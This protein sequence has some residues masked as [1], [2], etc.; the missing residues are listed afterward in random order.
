MLSSFQGGFKMVRKSDDGGFVWLKN[1]KNG[2]GE[3][4]G[5]GRRVGCCEELKAL[6]R[7]KSGSNKYKYPTD[8]R[9]GAIF[10]KAI[11]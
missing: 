9:L 2:G 3:E 7:E 8:F 11:S 6:M 1:M 4:K 5:N 10:W